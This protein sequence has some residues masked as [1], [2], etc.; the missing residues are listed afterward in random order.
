MIAEAKTTI[1]LHDLQF[2]LYLSEAE[3]QARVRELGAQITQQ[4]VGKRPLFI[5]VLNG[6]F[7]FVADLM[8]A[9][10]LDAEIS[11]IQLASYNGT[12]STGEIK[13]LIGL[14]V[15]VRNRHVILVE[16][17]IDTG[18][19]MYHFLPEL[20]KMQPASVAVASL[21]TKPEAMQHPIPI[22]FLGFEIPPKFVVGYGL[23]YNE[24]GRNLRDIYQRV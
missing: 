1:Q 19:T 8:R 6:S 10:N 16:D 3:I 22:D 4:Y 17:I 15:D 14:N 2:E 9:C 18:Q 20:K 23:D 24:L 13:T 5:G 12:E 7:L 11:F 21:L